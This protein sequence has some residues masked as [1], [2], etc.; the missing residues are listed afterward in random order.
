MVEKNVMFFEGLKTNV[1]G[2]A[3]VPLTSRLRSADT[4]ADVDAD[5]GFSRSPTSRLSRRG[6]YVRMGRLKIPQ[7]MANFSFCRND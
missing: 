6:G 2:F 4:P 1:S 3:D 7:K 5:A